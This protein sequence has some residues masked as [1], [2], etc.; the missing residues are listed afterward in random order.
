M[1]F[2]PKTFDLKGRIGV[3][4]RVAYVPQQPWI[5]NMTLRDNITFGRPFDRKR[6]DQVLHACALK[7]DIK[8]LPA[9]DRT[10]IGEKGINLSGGQKARVSLARAVYQNLDV[11]LL[12]DPLSAVDAHVGRHIFEKVIGPNGIL[13]EKTRILVTHGLTFTKF[14]DE[15]LVMHD[16]RLEET[17][18]FDALMKK[19]GVFFDFME[20]YKSSSDSDTNS[21]TSDDFDEI[22]GEKDDYVNPE[23]VVLTVTNDLDESVKTP[24]LTTQISTLSSPE[25]SP[26]TDE[27]L[28][29]KEA[30]AQGSVEIATYHLYVKAAGYSFS[31]AFI[32]FFILYTTFQTLRSFWLSAWSDE[33]DPDSPSAHPMAI[34]WRLGVYGAL[35]CVEV[36]SFF[37]AL[38]LL[39]FV[40]QRASKNLHGP[41]IHNLM[42]SP[43]S[44][45]DTTPLGRILNRCAKDI[46]TIDMQL[47]M[48]FR[49]LVMCALQVVFT[50]LV[51][52]ISTPLFAA[53][54]L[55]LGI[56]Y[57]IVLKYYVPTSRQLKR[58]ES[59]YRSPIYSHF[60]ETI[61]GAASIRAFN[62]LFGGDL[63]AF[64]QLYYPE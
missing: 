54:I 7:A 8:I 10:E 25:K 41:L 50:L 37:L 48:N 42:R 56:I 39:V 34:G 44:F 9:G 14:A 53:V 23:D 19:R 4:G 45:Y 32:A 1:C 31:I 62:K 16:G 30:V 18:T 29:K 64:W 35:G 17:G 60:G 2:S 63:G 58:L 59:V 21:E 57:L 26:V 40:G 52:I 24:E 38:I 28:I 46:E 3:N 49:Y 20:E 5:Q 61:Q 36:G 27:K 12:D 55:P 33:Y 6:Y 11:Y 13:R 15:I 51:I 22:G 43:M 47:P